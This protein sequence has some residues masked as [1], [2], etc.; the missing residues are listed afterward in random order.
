MCA[1]YY[2]T[3][4]IDSSTRQWANAASEANIYRINK[5]NSFLFPLFAYTSI[6]HSQSIHS[7][8]S[9]TQIKKDWIY[10]QMKQ[11]EINKNKLTTRW[12]A[13]SA[14]ISAKHFNSTLLF[15]IS[16]C[17][18]AS[19]DVKLVSATL[20]NFFNQTQHSFIHLIWY[21]F[22][23]IFSSSCSLFMYRGDLFQYTFSYGP[24]TKNRI[25]LHKILVCS[26]T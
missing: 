13:L 15:T 22:R 17:S 1:V 23:I 18:S 11:T 10:H 12:M 7:V 26:L 21:E 5:T 25:P 19:I 6:Q 8:I 24:P 16:G 14:S 2:E 9:Y 3:E 4:C 20:I